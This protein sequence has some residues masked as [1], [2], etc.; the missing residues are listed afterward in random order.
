MTLCDTAPDPEEF[1]ARNAANIKWLRESFAAAAQTGAAALMV[2]A[3][4]NPGWDP[5]DPTRAPVRNA[6]TLAQTDGAPDGFQ[7]FLLALRDQVIAFRFFH[8]SR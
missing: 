2:I 3:Q 8:T 1:Q 4:A 7:E 6:R 5:S